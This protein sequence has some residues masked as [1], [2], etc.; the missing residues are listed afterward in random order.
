MGDGRRRQRT[1]APAPSCCAFARRVGRRCCG[2]RGERQL[3]RHRPAQPA[4]WPAARGRGWMSPCADASAS[5]DE[6]ASHLLAKGRRRVPPSR[7]GRGHTSWVGVGA[8]RRSPGRMGPHVVD[9]MEPWRPRA[10]C[11][12]GADAGDP[13]RLRR[14]GSSELPRWSCAATEKESCGLGRTRTAWRRGWAVDALGANTG[15]GAALRWV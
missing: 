2:G 6:A 10:S 11:W 5:G 3:P 15:F 12:E 13:R 4:P 7:K 8:A 1:R 14:R 9:G